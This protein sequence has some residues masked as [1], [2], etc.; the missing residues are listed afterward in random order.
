MYLISKSLI[1]YKNNHFYY[2]DYEYSTL[3]VNL[4]RFRR[5]GWRRKII[6]TAS[7]CIM[8]DFMEK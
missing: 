2:D 6:L 8:D 5:C 1:E 4:G 3:L 7:I